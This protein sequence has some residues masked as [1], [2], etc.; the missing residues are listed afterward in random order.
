MTTRRN[1]H[2][3]IATSITLALAACG[4]SFLAQAEAAISK[5]AKIV[6]GFPPGGAADSVARLLANQLGNAQ[7]AAYAPSVIVDNKPGAGGRIAWQCSTGNS[8]Q[9]KYVPAECRH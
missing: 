8:N 1:F 7:G 6:V 3:N 5:P 2:L 4:M 9:W